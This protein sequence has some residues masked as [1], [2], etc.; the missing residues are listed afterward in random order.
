MPHIFFACPA[1]GT[2]L[3]SLPNPFDK[4][5]ASSTDPYS[6]NSRCMLNSTGTSSLYYSAVAA[7]LRYLD[8]ELNKAKGYVGL[9]QQGVWSAEYTLN[10][11]DTV[12]V[13]YN[14]NNGL[15]QAVVCKRA[16]DGTIQYESYPKLGLKKKFATSAPFLMAMIPAMREKSPEFDLNFQ[17]FYR[18]YDA[19]KPEEAENSLRYLVDYMFYS[20]EKGEI[21]CVNKPTGIVDLLPPRSV[22]SGVLEGVPVIGKAEFVQGTGTETADAENPVTAENENALGVLME[23][24]MFKSF[25]ERVAP[26][27]SKSDFDLIPQMDKKLIVPKW[28]LRVAIS[29]IVRADFVSPCNSIRIEGPTGVGK[30]F[31]LKMVAQLLGIPYFSINLNADTDTVSLKSQ[32]VPK[33]NSTDEKPM[34][35]PTEEDFIY[36]P[37]R[38]WEKMTGEKKENVTEEEA[39]ALYSRIT[40]KEKLP[41]VRVLS[42]LMEPLHRGI[43][44]LIE[45]QELSRARPGVAS[46]LNEVFD[47]EGWIHLEATGE[48]FKR[49]PLSLIVSTDNF[50]Y[51]G[52][53]KISPDVRR[54]F[55]KCIRLR[56]PDKDETVAR[57]HKRIG[58]A[59]LTTLGQ[60]YDI[61]M[62]VAKY[63]AE[64]NITDGD[65]GPAELEDWASALMMEPEYQLPENAEEA[66]REQ[67]LTKATG[68]S[69]EEDALFKEVCLS[70]EATGFFTKT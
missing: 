21:R 53:K 55:K 61:V 60:M 64:H 15:Y 43:P 46:G 29:Y 18:K 12:V 23:L 39:R 35:P 45:I 42:D 70:S 48:R 14:S 59:D 5:N 51:A 10:T 63:C 67:V 25:R 2:Y 66:F 28:A 3:S 11:G 26:L 68:D 6:P 40:S 41:F 16:S 27:L 17:E 13:Q 65:V 19:G 44:C 57:I 34:I 4:W 62:F 69:E 30:S 33:T 36:A 52:C 38:A 50:G 47:V 9:V 22:E 24:P 32:V 31:A 58:F 49:N 54:R 1:E 37:E 8:I 20:I 56:K 7:I